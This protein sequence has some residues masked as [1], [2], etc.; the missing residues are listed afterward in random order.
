MPRAVLFDLGKVLVRFDHGLTLARIE[1]A[2]SVP[3]ATLAPHLYGPLVGEYDLGRLET[4]AFFRAV[5]EAAGLPP[6]EDALWVA[7]WRDIFEPDPD[8]LALLAQLSP[9]MTPVLVSNTNALHWE[10]VLLVAPELPRLIPLRALSFEVG[11]AKPD[12]AHFQAAL[13][14]ARAAPREAVFADD[15]PENVV[16]A[17]DVG[18]DAF[19]VTDAASLRTGLEMR[20]VLR[21]PGTGATLHPRFGRGLEEFRAGRFFE[22]HEEWETLWKESTGDEK[23][24]LQALIQ[25]AAAAVHFGRGNREP[26]I[27]LLSLAEEKLERFGER[28]AGIRLEF[29]RRGIQQ[30]R[31]R[32]RNGDAPGEAVEAL[33]M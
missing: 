17:R 12:P 23:V 33:R 3:R 21:A 20:G 2:T 7:A 29:L 4:G 30:A 9:D 15:R 1:K 18:I 8:A 19:Q 11:A 32:L 26:G 31:E 25:V 10:G 24:F 5:E 28:Y 14:L 13:A 22:A 6:L 27:R 16:A